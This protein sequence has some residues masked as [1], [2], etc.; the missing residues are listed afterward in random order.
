MSDAV[1]AELLKLATDG[2]AEEYWHACADPALK[3]SKLAAFVKSRP[4]AEAP[5]DA[6]VAEIAERRRLKKDEP[7]DLCDWDDLAESNGVLCRD[8]DYLLAKLRAITSA[9]AEA[10]AP[11]T[12]A[13]ASV[14]TEDERAAVAD[15]AEFIDQ[16][17]A[18]VSLRHVSNLYAIIHRL[19]FTVGAPA[20][21]PTREQLNKILAPHRCTFVADCR[22]DIVNAILALIAKGDTP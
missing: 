19:A 4:Q 15:A 2:A 1:N 9:Q 8:I 17:Q 5:T 10:Q 3:A 14:L 7:A 18:P 12:A 20:P 13:Q 11:T 6:E 22:D 16:T 21:A